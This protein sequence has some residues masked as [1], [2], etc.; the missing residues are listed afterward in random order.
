MTAK[1]NMIRIENG[2]YE[3]STVKVS[4]DGTTGTFNDGLKAATGF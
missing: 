3:N 2:Y 1:Y 4:Y